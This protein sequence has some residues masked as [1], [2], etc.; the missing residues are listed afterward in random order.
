MLKKIYGITA[1]AFLLVLPGCL[2]LKEPEFREVKSFRLGKIDLSE[3]TAKMDLA[4][5]N[6][7]T[8]FSNALTALLAK[9]VNI[10]ISGSIKVGKAGLNK[11][12]PVNYEGKQTIQF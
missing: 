4:R 1:L 9:E 7:S 5:V 2:N 8:V 11:T 3:T 12:F 6:L 10:K